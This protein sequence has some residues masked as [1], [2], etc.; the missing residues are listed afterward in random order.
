[1]LIHGELKHITTGNCIP[2]SDITILTYTKPHVAINN[3]TERNILLHEEDDILSQES[4]K[5]VLD[6]DHDY[7]ADPSRLTEFAKQIIIYIAGFVVQRL[8]QQIKCSECLSVLSQEK[9]Q[10]LQFKKDKGSLHYPSKDVIVICEM[11]EKIYAN[12]KLF[13]TKNPLHHLTQ[14]CLKAF[15]N[16]KL[17]TTLS[18]HYKDLPVIDNHYGLLIKSISEKYLSVRM[19]YTAKK[20]IG[21]QEKVRNM[22]TKLILFKGQ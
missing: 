22:Y 1:M 5:P 9:F 12:N 17:F 14:K 10:S 7:L 3:T 4:D 8:E 19:H 11:A 16:K 21:Q 15:I 6:N 13:G 20:V 18:Q 2:L